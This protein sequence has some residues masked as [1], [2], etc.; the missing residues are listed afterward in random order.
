MVHGIKPMTLSAQ[1]PEPVTNAV[2]S[3]ASEKPT[4]T[5]TFSN[6]KYY[7]DEADS[8]KVECTLF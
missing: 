5:V 4:A 1:N 6:Y 2:T 8:V 7:E 3:I